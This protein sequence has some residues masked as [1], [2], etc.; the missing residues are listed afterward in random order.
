MISCSIGP[1][2]HREVCE[3]ILRR[4]NGWEKLLAMLSRTRTQS[5]AKDP[6]NIRSFKQ[7]ILPVYKM[8]AFDTLCF[9]SSTFRAARSV[10]QNSYWLH[11]SLSPQKGMRKGI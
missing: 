10:L 9:P 4:I 1:R 11:G 5:A 7:L 2:S 6:T 8:H 3:R